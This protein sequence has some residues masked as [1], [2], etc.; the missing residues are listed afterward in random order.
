MEIVL[1][2]M[3]AAIELEGRLF[4]ELKRKAIENRT[5]LRYRWSRTCFAALWSGKSSRRNANL[6]GVLIREAA[7]NPRASE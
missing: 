2:C 1:L 4:R 3:R 6:T 5:T 7:F